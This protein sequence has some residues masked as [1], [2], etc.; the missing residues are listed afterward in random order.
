MKLA[1]NGEFALRNEAGEVKSTW[2][3]G[4]KRVCCDIA[5]VNAKSKRVD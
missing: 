2:C 5:N 4:K 1:S 3:K